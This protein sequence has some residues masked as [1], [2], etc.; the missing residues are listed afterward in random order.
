VN[1][2]HEEVLLIP[3]WIDAERVTFKYGLG[4]EFINVLKV[5]HCS[6]SIRP[7]RSPW[8]L[9]GSRPGTSSPP[10]FPDPA[11]IGDRMHGLTCAGTWVRGT[12]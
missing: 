1:V 5:L 2:E 6:G 8:G 11:E 4:D 10:A 9:P 12:E 7:A 3:R